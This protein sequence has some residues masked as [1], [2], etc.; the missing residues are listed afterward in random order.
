MVKYLTAFLLIA[1]LSQCYSQ[2]IPL[3]GAN[4]VRINEADK[5]ILFDVDPVDNLSDMDFG[6]T[7]YWYASN[8][9]H[10]TQ[11]G[12]SGKLLNGHYTEFYLN[13]GLKEQGTFKKGLK[14]GLWKEWAETGQLVQSV[15]WKKGIKSG[16][17][18]S[19]DTNGKVEQQ[20]TFANNVLNGVLYKNH[21][22]DSVDMQYYRNGVVVGKK[23]P[24]L[25][26]INIFRKK[27][28]ADSLKV[29]SNT[30]EVRP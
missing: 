2:N 15:T 30:G 20:G 18:R 11:G 16:E 29:R 21:G 8:Q 12:F 22:K 28:Q 27:H 14:Q 4:R 26:R 24:F 7:Y 10:T 9:I 5:T 25:K 17:F 3:I 19:Y 23:P 6:L 13:K 1:F